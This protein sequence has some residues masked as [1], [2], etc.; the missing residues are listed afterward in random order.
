MTIKTKIIMKL[1]IIFMMM[2]VISL[3]KPQPKTIIVITLHNQLI[4]HSLTKNLNNYSISSIIQLLKPKMLE[5]GL[6]D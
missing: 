4:L 2:M 1:R 3:I 6:R 5:L